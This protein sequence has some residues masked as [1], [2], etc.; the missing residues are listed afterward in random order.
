MDFKVCWKKKGKGGGSTRKS[1]SPLTSTV[2]IRVPIIAP[3][4]VVFGRL[5]WLNVAIA[6]KA[7][8]DLLSS[9]KVAS[10]DDPLPPSTSIA[11]EADDTAARRLI[12]SSFSNTAVGMNYRSCLLASDLSQS[13]RRQA[14]RCAWSSDSF[15]FFVNLALNSL[16]VTLFV[17]KNSGTR[18]Y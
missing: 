15:E 4:N 1:H 9:S 6:E 8:L 13:N 16:L 12:S 2:A 10:M 18:N 5:S 3:A 14:W 11:L 7:L 17:C